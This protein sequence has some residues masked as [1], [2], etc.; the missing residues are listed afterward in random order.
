L[1]K[2]ELRGVP[3]LVVSLTLFQLSGG[4]AV[5]AS[6]RGGRKEGRMDESREGGNVFFFD[7]KIESKRIS[8]ERKEV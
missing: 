8:E 7:E 4:V 1:H 3:E 5:L 6:E 2:L